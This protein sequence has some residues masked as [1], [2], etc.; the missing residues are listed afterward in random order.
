[1]LNFLNTR[2]Y[3]ETILPASL[4][5]ATIIGAGVFSL[6]Y[7]VSKAGWVIGLG[8]LLVSPFI[9][10]FLHAM[11]ADIILRS[12]DDFKFVGYA[13]YYLGDLAF[14]LSILATV[15]GAIL[16][17]NAYIILAKSFSSI[18]FPTLPTFKYNLSWFWM[19]GSA[20]IFINIRR[21]AKIEF[22]IT[23]AMAVLI[24]LIFVFGLIGNPGR[25]IE[26]PKY[27]FALLFLPFGPI[28]FS[29]SGRTAIPSVIDYYKNNGIPFSN[30]KKV[31][32][33]GTMAP[34]VIYFMF[35]VGVI[36]ISKIITSDS[37]STINGL[38][39]SL[40][41]IIGITG[42][43]SLLSSYVVIGISVKDILSVDLKIHPLISDLITILAPILLIF[44]G[45]NNFI[46]VITLAGGIFL[47]LE[48]IVVVAMW[49]KVET[50]GLKSFL[51]KYKIPN[52]VSYIL[53]TVFFLGIL[54]VAAF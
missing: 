10:Y 53:L 35:V 9:F 47:A 30:L 31:I 37:V 42:L 12:R 13:K 14:W 21:M 26:L 27:D 44:M 40:A 29:F 16:T 20:A 17:L 22:F 32:F 39:Y 48:G 49:R 38:P 25:I 8:Y 15:L 46:K 18:I 34:A 5:S 1:M 54:Y 6:P 36:G 51:F 24:L 28:L 7:I 11:Y 41:V 45:F 4:L 50:W 52:I 33:L 23:V 19:L 43:L 3:R 2:K